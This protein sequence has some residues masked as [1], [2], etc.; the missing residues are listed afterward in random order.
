MC[1]VPGVWTLPGVGKGKERK[2]G[3]SALPGKGGSSPSRIWG[4]SLSCQW[5]TE[6]GT[7]EIPETET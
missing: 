3:S 4:L 1:G 6:Q 5:T 7:G 2:S